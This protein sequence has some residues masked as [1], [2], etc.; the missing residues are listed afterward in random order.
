MLESS[1]CERESSE[2][3]VVS[4]LECLTVFA[5][6]FDSCLLMALRS[7]F[8]DDFCSRVAVSEALVLGRMGSLKLAGLWPSIRRGVVLLTLSLS[9]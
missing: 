9:F 2:L 4:Y 8:L 1:G 6:I 3:V 5:Y 7:R